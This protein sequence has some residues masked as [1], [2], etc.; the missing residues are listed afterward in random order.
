MIA[1]IPTD[2]MKIDSIIVKAAEAYV[3]NYMSEHLDKNFGFHNL[4]H[5]LTV[6]KAVETICVE[7]GIDKH[8]K[9]IL[10][11]AAWFHDLG[12]TQRIDEH[13]D[14]G[15]LLAEKFLKGKGVDESDIEL[16]KSDI[17]ATHFPQHPLTASEK[18]LCDADMIHL[19]DK[20]YFEKADVLRKEWASTRNKVYTDEEWLRI[21]IAFL[22]DHSYHTSYCRENFDERKQKNIKKLVLFLRMELASF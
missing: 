19:A 15:A 11:V 1:K 16:V 6:V 9:R 2:K 13:E 18:I 22:S 10:Q 4:S 14:I 20:N 21:N 12:Y 7:S 3:R 5:T 17:I 8:E